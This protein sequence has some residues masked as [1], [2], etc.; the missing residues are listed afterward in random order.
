M[1]IKQ[2][3]SNTWKECFEGSPKLVAYINGVFSR[4]LEKEYRTV[5]QLPTLYCGIKME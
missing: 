2:N 5:R 1:Y 3:L 4:I